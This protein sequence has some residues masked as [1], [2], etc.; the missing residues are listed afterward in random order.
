MHP[1]SVIGMIA[2]RHMHEFGTTPEQLAA[3]AVAARAWALKNPRA[4][5]P[6]PLAVEDVLASPLISSPLHK[7]DCC[8]VT[9]GGAA[10]V[11]TSAERAR[12]LKNP[13]I[14]VLGFGEAHDHRNIIGMG[15]LTSTRA[16][17]SAQR[18]YAMA[19]IEAKDVDT[20]HVY[21]AFTISLMILLEDLGFCAKGEAG[22]FVEGGAI[23]PGGEL[24]LNTNGGGL[25]Y[26]HPGMLGM[27]LLTE[28]VAQLRGQAGE[29]QIADARTSLVHGM[30]LTLGAHATVMLGNE[31]AL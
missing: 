2:Q 22:P 14:Y 16:V 27:F 20:A 5:Y 11:L 12:D 21:D 10:L 17:E 7:L 6:T 3:A 29:R 1:I 24:P 15:D 31:R 19:G 18:A 8:L 28:A 9:D 23:A 26:T 13:P 4:P 25:S 30:G